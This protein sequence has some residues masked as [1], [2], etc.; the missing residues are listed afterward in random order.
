VGSRRSVFL[1]LALERSRVGRAAIVVTAAAALALL[2]VSPVKLCVVARVFHVPCPGCGLTRAT[3]AIAQGDVMRAL[4][5]HPL[6]IVLVPIVGFA[7]AVHA[8]RYVRTGSAWNRAR[9][10][11]MTEAALAALALLLIAVWIA[12]FFGCFGG[13]VAI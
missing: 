10:S 7:C 3:L 11:R 5:L 9:P 6:S 13:P 8:L 12:R 2:A 1:S 4:A